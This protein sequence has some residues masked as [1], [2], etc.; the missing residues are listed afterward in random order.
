MNSSI[1]LGIIDDDQ[2]IVDLLSS[3]FKN[4]EDIEV[5]FT[6][7]NGLECI[8]RISEQEPNVILMD[9][10]MDGLGGV[11]A[12]ERIRVMF[13]GVK[14]ILISSH[15]NKAF[16][17]FMLKSGAA[18]FVPKGITPSELLKCVREVH[19]KGYYFLQEQMDN[20][21]NQISP[22]APKP[23]EQNSN[24]LSD[25]EIEVLRLICQQKTAQEIADELFITK[26]TVE[27]HKNNLFLK[28]GAK[29]VVGLVIYAIQ[30]EVIKA[31]EIPLI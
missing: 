9:V 25:R 23:L 26:R 29:N 16:I 10:R 28:T 3:F 2:L 12:L 11:E 13:S 21:R 1:K 30:N 8:E 4:Q 19:E 7:N 20:I 22:K 15:Y 18:A 5:V 27:G 17:G 31:E 6:A 14:C 24:A